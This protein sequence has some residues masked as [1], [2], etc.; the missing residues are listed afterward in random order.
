VTALTLPNAL[1]SVLPVLVDT[2]CH[3]MPDRLALAI[4]KYFDDV[5]WKPAYPSVLKDDVVRAER[6]AGVER[7]WALPYAHKAGIASALNEWMASEVAGIPGAVAAATFHPDDADLP[8]LVER[9]FDDL[10]LRVAKLHCSVGR[11]EVDDPRFEPLWNAA[12][13]RGVPVVVH[14]G[15]SENGRTDAHEL[16][17]IGRIATAHPRLR[18]V[19]AHAGLPDIDT[20]L[21]LL[22]RH[23]ALHADLTSAHEWGSPL[24]VGRLE[25]LHERLLFGSDCP[26]TA[27]TIAASIEGLRARGFSPRALRAILGENAARLV[28]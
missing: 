14:A 5:G 23:V 20:T 26:N 13:A 9:A 10:G 28:P 3:I 27:T 25:A 2:H 11:F 7:F 24:T 19:I 18:L 12:E 8:A 21:D 4:R 6:E 17:P 15:H 1:G 16:A 22:E